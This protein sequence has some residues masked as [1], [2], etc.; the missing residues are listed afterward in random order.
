MG[1][2][3]L[4]ERYEMLG[5][6]RVLVKAQIPFPSSLGGS[7]LVRVRVSAGEG[8]GFTVTEEKEAV[9]L[10]KDL[11]FLPDGQV[12]LWAWQDPSDGLVFIGRHGFRIP[13]EEI[14]Q[15]LYPMPRI[16]LIQGREFEER[17]E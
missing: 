11:V 12:A 1:T 8:E 2:A 13:K 7:E 3:T 10:G 14:L 4:D 5:F 17:R 6:W 16:Y 15:T 9:P